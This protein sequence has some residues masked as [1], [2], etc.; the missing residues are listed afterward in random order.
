[1]LQFLLRIIT[2]RLDKPKLVTTSLVLMNFCNRYLVCNLLRSVPS[3]NIGSLTK[4]L[5][6]ISSS[7]H[8]LDVLPGTFPQVEETAE[9]LPV[10]LNGSEADL[11]GEALPLG[12]EVVLPG[13]L[14]EVT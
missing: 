4:T 11:A 7:L 5:K 6:M 14:V 12:V 9:V 10:S 1:M 2:A 8:P 13:H 3:Y